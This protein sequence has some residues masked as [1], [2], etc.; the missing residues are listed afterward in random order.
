MKCE[1]SWIGKTLKQ[2]KVGELTLS[3]SIIIIQVQS[4]QCG[5]GINVEQQINRTRDKYKV[6]KYK[7]QGTKVQG[8]CRRQH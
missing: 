8:Q 3:V 5:T 4:R 1:A 2:N 6:Q 7:V